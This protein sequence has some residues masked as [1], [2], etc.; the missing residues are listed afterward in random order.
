MVWLT[1]KTAKGEKERR[2]K[3]TLHCPKDIDNES[4]ALE[5]LE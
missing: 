2:E 4:R 3:E 5:R 1:T